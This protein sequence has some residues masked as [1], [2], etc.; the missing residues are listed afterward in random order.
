MKITDKILYKTI[1]PETFKNKTANMLLAQQML[2]FMM[3]SGG[4]GLAAN[5]VGYDK[6]LFI[7]NVKQPKACFN[8]EVIKRSALEEPFPEG[9]LS[10]KNEQVIVDR[11]TEIDV[12]YY[13]FDGQE[14]RET[15]TG[16]EARCFLHELDHLNGITMYKRTKLNE[17]A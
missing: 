1:A 4:I 5:Q 17:L 3:K 11:P 10:F 7:I 12:K 15:M 8:P 2:K 6:R 9:C 13:T 16:L 14:V